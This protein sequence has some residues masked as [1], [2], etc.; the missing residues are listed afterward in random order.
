VMYAGHIAETGP[1][2]EVLSRPRHPYTQLLL[3]G[4]PT[5]GRRWRW[6]RRPTGA[7][8]PGSSTPPP[9]AGSAG[10]ARWPPTSAPGSPRRCGNCCPSTAPR[11]TSPKRTPRPKPSGD[12]IMDLIVFGSVFLELVFSH[13]PA[14]PGPGEEIYSDEFAMSCGGAVIVAS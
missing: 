7:S 1:T 2:E 10:A 3:S 13:V 5:R 9:A 14:L 4:S 12:T 6:G 8:R 11:V